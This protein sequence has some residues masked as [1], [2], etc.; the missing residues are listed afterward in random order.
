MSGR[1]SE[2]ISQCQYLATFNKGMQA[3]FN[4]LLDA[5]SGQRYGRNKVGSEDMKDYERGH[6][7][8][9]L[10][11]EIDEMEAKHG[12]DQSESSASVLPREAQTC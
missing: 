10:L 11:K 5:Q 8:G 3:E 4:G 12:H 1:L 7:D 6:R 2:R 9:L